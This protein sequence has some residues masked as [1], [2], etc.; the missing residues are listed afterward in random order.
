MFVF[1]YHQCPAWTKKQTPT[2]LRAALL[3]FF[4]G[5]PA[6]GLGG[7]QLMN[8]LQVVRQSGVGRVSDSLV[9]SPPRA[10]TDVAT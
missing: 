10:V 9:P 8:P 2:G 4:H 7:A 5:R 3:V 6:L 1:S